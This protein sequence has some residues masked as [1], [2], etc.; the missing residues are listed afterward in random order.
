VVAYL[1]ERSLSLFLLLKDVCQLLSCAGI[2]WCS[3]MDTYSI[4]AALIEGADRGVKLFDRE[5]HGGQESGGNSS[6]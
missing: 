2:P 1:V 6:R 4:A 5:R 3:L